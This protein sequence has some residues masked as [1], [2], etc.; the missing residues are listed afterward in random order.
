MSDVLFEYDAELADQG[1][2]RY[3]ARAAGRERDDGRWEGWLEFVPEDGGPAVRTG[4]ETTQPDRRFLE[5]WATGLTATYLDGALLR[6]TTP[7]PE[8]R[9][10]RTEPPPVGAPAPR[11]APRRKGPAHHPTRPL[12]A[13]AAAT[14]TPVAVLD[15]FAVFAE[16]DQVLRGQLRALASGQLR[17]IVKA[18]RLSTLTSD[19]LERLGQSA[20]V[21]LI[22]GEVSD[23]ADRER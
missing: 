12:E 20:L 7:E 17:N 11:R 5:Y 22:M 16:G 9:I 2:R 15:P 23:R 19:E 13:R 1:G 3:R 8:V 10:V 18:Y 6:A 4:R 14:G 21:G